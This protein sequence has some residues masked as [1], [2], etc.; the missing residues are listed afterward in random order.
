MLQGLT[1]KHVVASL[2]AVAAPW[3]LVGATTNIVWPQE[4]GYHGMQRGCG[5]Y[6]GGCDEPEKAVGNVDRAQ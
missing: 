6:N 1:R 2:S 3:Q 5:T 4:T